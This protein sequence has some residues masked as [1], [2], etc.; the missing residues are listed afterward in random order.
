MQFKLY[1]LKLPSI[2]KCGVQ[3]VGRQMQCIARLEPCNASR[4]QASS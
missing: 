4:T 3:I 1:I 2:T